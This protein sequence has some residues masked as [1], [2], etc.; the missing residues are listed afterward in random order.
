[1]NKMEYNSKYDYNMFDP[2]LD[3]DY[4][5]KDLPLETFYLNET[6]H[7]K[8]DVKEINDLEKELKKEIKYFLGE[9]E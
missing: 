5:G 4:V 6:E 8:Y 2:W 3:L 7:G 9:D 1:M